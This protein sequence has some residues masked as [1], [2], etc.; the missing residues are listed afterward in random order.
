MR[1]KPHIEFE[2]VSDVDGWIT[3]TVT[4]MELNKKS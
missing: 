3:L 4:Q 2:I 1:L